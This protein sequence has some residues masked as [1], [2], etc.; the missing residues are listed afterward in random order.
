MVKK[1]A[2]LVLAVLLVFSTSVATAHAASAT[3]YRDDNFSGGQVNVTGDIECFTSI[4]FNDELSSVEVHEGTFTLFSDCDYGQPS[5]TISADG[6]FQSSG[7]YPNPNWIG[8]R[9][10][11]YSSIKVNK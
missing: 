11:Y 1:L 10:D 8:G 4:G 3:L 2:S 9:N 7:E 5:V 6:G